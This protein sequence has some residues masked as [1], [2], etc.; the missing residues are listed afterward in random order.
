[1]LGQFAIV[2]VIKWVIDR[3]RPDLAQLTGYAGASFPSGHAAAA[4]ATWACVALVLGRRRPRSVRALLAGSG[5]A[6]A[7]AVAATRVFL[8]VHWFT[9]VLAGLAL[10]W[11]W[12]AMCSLAFGGQHLHFGR[13]IEQ[14][15]AES[16]GVDRR[17][18]DRERMC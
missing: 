10:G 12:F 13:T 16:A 4:A 2:N 3:A 7:T 9:D 14:A 18:H 8:G 17:R 5:V 6:I 11:G 15:E 1:V